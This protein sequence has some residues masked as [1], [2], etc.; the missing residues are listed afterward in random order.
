MTVKEIARNVIDAL[1]SDASMDDI[2]HALYLNAKFT[3][4]DRE[5]RSG[6]GIAHQDA[7]KRLQK[8]VK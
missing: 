6:H 4:G 7:K 8:W 1:P 3:R 2:I 5:I